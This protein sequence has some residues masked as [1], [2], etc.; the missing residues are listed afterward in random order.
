MTVLFHAHSG[1]RYLVLLSGAV[2]VAWFLYAWLAGRGFDRPGRIVLAAFTGLL[3][4][5]VVLGLALLVGGRRTPGIGAHVGFMVL[6][7]VVAHVTSGV[8]R[9]RP[10]RARAVLPLAGTILALTVL[11]AGIL[12]IRPSVL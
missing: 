9:R 5:Q 1:L 11:A 10:E 3:D 6:A 7:V 12:A 2:A 4:L 8:A